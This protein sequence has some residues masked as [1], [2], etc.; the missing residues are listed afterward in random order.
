MTSTAT[1]QMGQP[2]MAQ[3]NG[4]DLP[5]PPTSMMAKGPPAKRRG[6]AGFETPAFVRGIEGGGPVPEGET[7]HLETSYTPINDNSLQVEWYKDGQ[8]VNAGEL[9]WGEATSEEKSVAYACG[10]RD[11]NSSVTVWYNLS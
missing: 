2:Q 6:S 11:P 10:T 3:M 4:S 1:L 7:V 9:C 8:P 5:P